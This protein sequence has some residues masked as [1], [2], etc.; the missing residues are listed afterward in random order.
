[1]VESYNSAPHS[2]LGILSPNDAWTWPREARNYHYE[3][4]QKGLKKS[5]RSKGSIAVGDY[6][7]VLKLKGVFDKGYNV[8]FSLGTHKVVEIKGL[9]YILD[10]GRFYRAARLQKV[11]PPGEEEAEPVRDVGQEARRV[12]RAEVILQADGVDPVANPERR[13][14]S[15]LRA[16]SNYVVDRKFGKIKWS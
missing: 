5:K 8:K 15:R 7:R 2:S 16:P 9:N 14:T 3:R 12:R 10:N 6:V 11:P 13:R 4:I 1:M